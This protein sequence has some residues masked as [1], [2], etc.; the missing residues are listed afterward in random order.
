MPELQQLHSDSAHVNVA[1]SDSVFRFEDSLSVQEESSSGP[2]TVVLFPH[3]ELPVRHENPVPL[4]RSV[5]DWI[6]PVL[7]AVLGLFAFLRIFYARYFSRLFSAF[8]NSSLANQVV[9]DEN[10]L[11][12]RASVLLNIVFYMVAALFLYFISS[13]RHW[14]MEGLDYGFSRYLFFAI[15]VAAVYT[16]KMIIL[17]ICGYVFELDREMAAYIFNIFLINSILGMAL[18]PVTGLMAYASWIPPAW[19]TVLALIIIS[20]AF[21]YRLVRGV[22]IAIATPGFSPVYLILYLC[23]LEIAPL[24]VV[25]K[26]VTPA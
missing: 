23:A 2:P 16:L 7:L 14:E 17:K 5:P 11:I 25:L 3:H 20:V 13:S 6:F 21:L 22:L 19:I 8:T 9:R 10:V 26:L 4:N 1:A 18:L 12:Q 15:L 24:L